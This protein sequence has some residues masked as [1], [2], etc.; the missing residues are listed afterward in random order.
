MLASGVA[1]GIIAGVAFGGDWR[2]LATFNLRLWPVLVLAVGLRF[3]G[4][5]VIPNSPLALYLVSLLGVSIVA[6]WDWRVPGA[7]LIAAG[8]S[9]NLLVA[10]LNSGM[11]YDPTAVAVA[12]A[13]PPND[14]LHVL[15]APDTRLVF[16]SDVIPVAA[17]RNV[18]SSAISL[19][20]SADFLSPS[21]GSSPQLKRTPLRRY[22][23]RILHSFG[24]PSW[25]V[26]LGIRSPSLR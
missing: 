7:L 11:P 5:F 14:G 13:P 26:G 16:L 6:G 25:S 19:T 24:P 4:D 12:S 20:Q 8:T 3:V 10:A 18:L 9:L 15:L 17:I 21:C 22:A 23:P 2:R 1:A